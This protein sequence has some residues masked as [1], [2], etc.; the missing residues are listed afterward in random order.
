MKDAQTAS[1]DM[2]PGSAIE[3]LLATADCDSGVRRLANE[4]LTDEATYAYGLAHGLSGGGELH[5]DAN[6]AGIDNLLGKAVPAAV[7]FALHH[8][9]ELLPDLTIQQW[10]R[11]DAASI[12]L[13]LRI[14]E[15]LTGA[16]GTGA[17]PCPD[18]SPDSDR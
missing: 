7:A 17:D 18:A 12:A 5:D 14:N 4:T 9:G 3:Q 2:V 8:L 13:H 10:E 15:D 11:I 1:G 6:S 16:N